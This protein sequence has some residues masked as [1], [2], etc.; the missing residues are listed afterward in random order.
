MCTTLMMARPASVPDPTELE[1]PDLGQCSRMSPESRLSP[2]DHPLRTL[3]NAVLTPHLGYVTIENYR[4][5]Y[6]Q[7][8]ENIRAFLAGAPVRVIAP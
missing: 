2:V 1:H 5:V 7:A 8:V 3:D 4:E 6:G